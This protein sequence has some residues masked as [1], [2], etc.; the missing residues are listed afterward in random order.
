MTAVRYVKPTP[1]KPLDSQ[2][3]GTGV[4][5]P[6]CQW[7]PYYIAVCDQVPGRSRFGTG[8]WSGPPYGPERAPLPVLL[9]LVSSAAAA[10][11]TPARRIPGNEAACR[12]TTHPRGPGQS[13]GPG[14][15]STTVRTSSTK[16]RARAGSR[17]GRRRY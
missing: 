7:D 8:R 5:R 11:R 15:S 16:P 2:L 14:R 6:A 9:S 1:T 13:A 4:N 17:G 12:W 10:A 3:D